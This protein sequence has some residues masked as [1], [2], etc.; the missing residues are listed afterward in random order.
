M[1]KQRAT[2]T[3]VFFH[4]EFCR[5]DWPVI[6]DKYANFPGAMKEQL[7]LPGVKLFEPGPASENTLL[8]AHTEAYLEEV[9]RSWY[10]TGAALAAGGCVEAAEHIARGELTNAL[11]F[12]VAA[13]HHAEPASGWGGTYLSCTGPAVATLREAH[14]VRR[15]AIID[16]D[17][18]HGNG[19]RAMFLD[20]PEVLH[21]CFCSYDNVTGGGTKVD[22]DAGFH[23]TDAAYLEKVE[24]EFVSR[25][26]AFSPWVIFH[27]FGHDTA[28]GDYGDRGL[29]RAFFLT[30]AERVKA[31]AE[32]V[33]AGRYIVITHGGYRQD[34]AEYIFPRI[35]E[36]LSRP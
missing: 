14:N 30:L 17:S 32:E 11:V 16:T 18:H 26:R 5:K 35:V 8:L 9:K 1:N 20:D 29:T 10:F 28:Q 15:V 2:R 22:V 34:L 6:G 33:C 7:A 24:R 3:G 36:I 19:T 25:C 4:P 12:S 23:T 21:V 27:N 31:C 13:G